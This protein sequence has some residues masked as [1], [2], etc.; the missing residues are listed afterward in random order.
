MYRRR[1]FA[2]CVDPRLDPSL[3]VDLAPSEICLLANL[4]KIQ[5][6]RDKPVLEGEKS[7][8]YF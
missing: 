4:Y 8:K 3:L 7:V 6:E 5:N 2:W 1:L